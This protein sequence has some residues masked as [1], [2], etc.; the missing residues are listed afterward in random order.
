MEKPIFVG[1]AIQQRE[2]SVSTLPGMLSES[3]LMYSKQIE[4]SNKKLKINM[5]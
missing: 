4:D 5:A 2:E 1:V 3:S